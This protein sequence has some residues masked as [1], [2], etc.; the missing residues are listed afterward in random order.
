MTTRPPNVLSEGATTW[1]AFRG[2]IRKGAPNNETIC[3]D[4]EVEYRCDASARIGITFRLRP[5]QPISGMNGELLN[6]LG[7]FRTAEGP[8]HD[9]FVLRT[10]GRRIAGGMYWHPVGD[11]LWESRMQPLDWAYPAMGAY[12]TNTGEFVAITDPRCSLPGSFENV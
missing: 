2:E 3:A 11:R 8:L 12:N 4:Y 5:S 6:A 10:T 9:D 7:N 1:I